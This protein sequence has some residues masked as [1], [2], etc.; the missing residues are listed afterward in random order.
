MAETNGKGSGNGTAAP[1]GELLEVVARQTVPLVRGIPDGRLAAATP[2]SEY[3]VRALANHLFHV[4]VEFTSLA[5]K[6]DADFSVTPDRVAEGEWRERFAGAV[7]ELVAA[8]SEPGAEDGTTG[9]MDMPARTVGGMVLL[10]LT[11]HGWDLA[12]ATGQDFRADEQV[13]A[14]LAETVAG[15]APTGRKM[16][17]FGDPVPVPEGADAFGRLLAETGRDPRWAAPAEG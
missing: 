8:W 9:A 4:V 13:T 12:R 15:L 3:D 16:G 7:A 5:G 14:V 17:V 6:G 11:V 2:C 10:D 1:M